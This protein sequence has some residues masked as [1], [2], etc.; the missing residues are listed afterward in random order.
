[1]ARRSARAG[2]RFALI[3]PGANW[4]N[5]R[6]PP[7][8]FGELASRIRVEH[9]LVSLVLWGPG[10][11]ALADAVVAASRGAA[12]RAPATSLRDIVHLAQRAAVV[13]A[14]D[15]GPFH[16][17]CGAGARTVGVFGPTDPKRNGSWRASDIAVSRFEACACHHLRACRASR[18]CLL[19]VEVAQVEV[20]VA[21]RLADHA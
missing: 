11:E 16:L 3:N 4:P 7:D 18:W 12:L 2:H 14:G 1:M 10:D 9:G 19:D 15:T 13:V 5:K 17:A 8:R 20:A 21:K 6:W